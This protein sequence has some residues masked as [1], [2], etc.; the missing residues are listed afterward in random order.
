MIPDLVHE[1]MMLSIL[2]C[3]RASG[4][5]GIALASTSIAIGARCPH[6]E[7]GQ[8]VIASQGFTN[9][10]VGPLALDLIRC[11]LTAGEVMEALRQ[12]DRWLDYRQIGILRAD[13]EGVAFTGARARPGAA[14]HLGK[15]FLCLG[16]GLPNADA[17]L[18]LASG[19]YGGAARAGVP[20]AERLLAGL[21]AVK[22]AL[23]A[24]FPIVSS[25]LLLRA[26]DQDAQIDLRVDMP[27]R[28]IAEGGNALG[29]LQ[30]LYADYLPLVDIYAARS[31][32]PQAF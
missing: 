2:A 7:T 4:A 1:G 17:V 18:A 30:R 23:G 13:G 24:G 10:K 27:S 19:A 16:N 6:I 28:P 8:A 9:L 5:L 21:A 14:H 26:P 15:G 32:A 31:V 22:A 11:G 3:D 29:D 12:H 25:S 20:L